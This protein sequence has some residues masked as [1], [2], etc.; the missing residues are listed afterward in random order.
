MGY[1]TVASATEAPDEGELELFDVN[2]TPVTVA[3]VEGQLHG[4]SDTCS[5]AECSLAEGELEENQVVCPC[6]GGS[7]DVTTGEVM[8][9]PPKQKI[10]TFPVRI[11][12][13][14]LQIDV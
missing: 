7:F 1:V 12:G 14:E 13:D 10:A 5:H 2:G 8:A 6:H 11:D 4:F 9:F 3:N